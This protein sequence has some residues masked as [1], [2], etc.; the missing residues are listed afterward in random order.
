MEQTSS[1]LNVQPFICRFTD[2]NPGS[3]KGLETWPRGAGTQA[4]Q[5]R[6]CATVYCGELIHA[7]GADLDGQKGLK[8][9]FFKQGALPGPGWQAQS[10]GQTQPQSR[11]G[12]RLQKG[13]RDWCTSSRP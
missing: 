10:R 7:A 5:G 1:I 12:P 4:F 3:L 11:W 8:P 9:F 13:A 6:S 2:Q